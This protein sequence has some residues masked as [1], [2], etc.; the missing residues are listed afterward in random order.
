MAEA[1]KEAQRHASEDAAAAR[2]EA[3]E[4]AER[5]RAGEQRMMELRLVTA[6]AKREVEQIEEKLRHLEVC[7]YQRGQ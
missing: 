7:T 3:S 5:L 1:A 6:G 4:A 2:A